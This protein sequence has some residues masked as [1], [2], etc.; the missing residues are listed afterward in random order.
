MQDT[1]NQP[2]FRKERDD[3]VS[4][5]AGLEPTSQDLLQDVVHDVVEEI[6]EGEVKEQSLYQG[7]EAFK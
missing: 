3:E 2:S 7:S 4:V 5:E 1:F 6:V